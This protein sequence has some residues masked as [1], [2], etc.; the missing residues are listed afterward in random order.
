M[1]ARTFLNAAA[2]LG[3]AMERYQFDLAMD[4]SDRLDTVSLS[5][6]FNF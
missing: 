2:G 6:V 1:N 4:F 5:G 3:L